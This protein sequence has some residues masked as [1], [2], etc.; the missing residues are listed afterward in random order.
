T[1]RG[2]RRGGRLVRC[3][4]L[5]DRTDVRGTAEGDDGAAAWCGVEPQGPAHPAHAPADAVQPEV[6]G[7]DELGKVLVRHTPAVVDDGDPAPAL[8]LGAGDEDPVATAVPGDVLQGL[9]D[10]GEPLRG[11]SGTGGH[12]DELGAHGEVWVVL[13]P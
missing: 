6:A 4:G 10:R 13:R 5:G 2:V 9:T 7:G 3:P 11:G 8:V 1:A 12:R